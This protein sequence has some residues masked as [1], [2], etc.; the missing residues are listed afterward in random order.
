M[1]SNT[2]R[3]GIE[4]RTGSDKSKSSIRNSDENHD[5]DS[6]PTSGTTPTTSTHSMKTLMSDGGKYSYS[7]QRGSKRSLC[8]H[9]SSPSLQLDFDIDDPVYSV[10]NKVHSKPDTTVHSLG[11]KWGSSCA[12][13][14]R[15][16]MEDRH[17]CTKINICDNKQSVQTLKNA[18]PSKSLAALA[19]MQSCLLPPLPPVVESSG[20]AVLMGVFDGHNGSLVAEILHKRWPVLIKSAVLEVIDMTS[21]TSSMHNVDNSAPSIDP[22]GPSGP[23]LPTALI[24]LHSKIEKLC[25]TMDREILAAELSRLL[26]KQRSSI[27]ISSSSP[28]LKSLSNSFHGSASNPN[29]VSL[30]TSTGISS[31]APSQEL[32]P[33]TMPATDSISRLLK[34]KHHTTCSGSTAALV[35][36]VEGVHLGIE[37]DTESEKNP[38]GMRN[39]YDKNDRV[40]ENSNNYA[41]IT[42]VGDTRVVLCT[43]GIA[44]QLTNDHRPTLSSEADRIVL[45]GGIVVNHRVGGVLGVT[46]C[47]GDLPYKIFTGPMAAAGCPA[48]ADGGEKQLQ[49]GL[50]GVDKQVISKPDITTHHLRHRDEFF[51]I[52]TDGLWDVMECQEAVNFVRWQLYEHADVDKAAS[53]LVREVVGRSSGGDNVTVVICCVNQI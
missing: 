36:I 42:H 33:M 7:N 52:A 45:A 5:S 44:Y 40:L 10:M 24:A 11:V 25:S 18:M 26:M 20:Q 6:T 22:E 23:T 48:E 31:T 17:V 1:S 19:S 2:N 27:R 12:Q 3:S 21:I 15:G 32:S 46:R 14:S 9:N 30:G 28:D 41:I 35:L 51:I 29:L 4:K 47:F 34:N 8:S 38:S 16:D 53:A 37:T 50:W 43:A 13:G 49:W 39:P